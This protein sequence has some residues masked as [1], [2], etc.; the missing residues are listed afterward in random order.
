[1]KKPTT[2]QG[3]AKSGLTLIEVDVTVSI[4]GIVAAVALLRSWWVPPFDRF[5]V[6]RERAA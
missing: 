4:I 1:M 5:C 2:S 6:P 3:L